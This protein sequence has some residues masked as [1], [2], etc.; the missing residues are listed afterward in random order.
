M[1]DG[2]HKPLIAIENTP[3]FVKDKREYVRRWLDT[4]D[5]IKAI[6]CIDTAHLYSSGLFD[7]PLSVLEFIQ[8][9]AKKR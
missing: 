2:V 4:C 5:K 6:P 1:G 8:K 7:S 9:V 3:F